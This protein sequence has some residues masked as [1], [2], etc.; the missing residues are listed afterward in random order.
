VSAITTD[1]IVIALLWRW[2]GSALTSDGSRS[3]SI[4]PTVLI[5]ARGQKKGAAAA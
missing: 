4:D 2:R 5:A 1:L 3:T